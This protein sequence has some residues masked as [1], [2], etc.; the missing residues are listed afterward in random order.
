M[1][2]LCPLLGSSCRDEECWIF[3]I[4]MYQPLQV[5]KVVFQHPKFGIAEI[6]RLVVGGVRT[7]NKKKSWGLYRQP[8]PVRVVTAATSS[9]SRYGVAYLFGP[10]QDSGRCTKKGARTNCNLQ[11]SARV[12]FEVT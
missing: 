7:P 3:P 9:F 12:A 6:L 10:S 2:L 1:R 5:A 4:P 11:A 8:S